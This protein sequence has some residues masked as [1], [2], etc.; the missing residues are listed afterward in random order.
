MSYYWPAP[1]HPGFHILGFCRLVWVPL[2][3]FGLLWRHGRWV[4]TYSRS[5]YLG[6][7]GPSV[8]LTGD[9]Q[10]HVESVITCS[11]TFK[12]FMLWVASCLKIE[13]PDYNYNYNT[14]LIFHTIV[15][16]LKVV[17]FPSN[18]EILLEF[19]ILKCLSPYLRYL[20]GVER[21]TELDV[22]I[23]PKQFGVR[24]VE[25]MK[26]KYIDHDGNSIT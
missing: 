9:P 11:Y 20:T 25:S 18:T 7:A 14:Y 12:A 23:I 5:Q 21:P 6:T 19:F 15:V 17:C 22:N 24:P 4:E 10:M 16:P 13:N 1:E 26:N 2:G 8:G 3:L